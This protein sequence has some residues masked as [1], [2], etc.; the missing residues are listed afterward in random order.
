MNLDF[1]II[2][3][4]ALIPL[5]MGFIWYHPKTFGNAWMN[6]AGL[7]EEKLKGANMALIFFLT[8]V[9]S[10]F[11]AMTMNFI[12]I[13]QW[14]VMS[15]LDVNKDVN[16]PGSPAHTELMSILDKHGNNFRTFKHGALHGFLNDIFFVFPLL[17]INALFERKSWKYVWINTGYWAI[18][19]LLMGGIACQFSKVY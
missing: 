2:L 14:S 17:A 11:L 3:A 1:P 4:S 7:T 5:L 15:L 9:F 19:F 6:A 8:Y 18:T 12:T 10:I 13:H 16:T